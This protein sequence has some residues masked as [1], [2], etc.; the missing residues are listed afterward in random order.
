M[1]AIMDKGATVVLVAES[2]VL[3]GAIGLCDTIKSG[4][5]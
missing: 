5:A 1:H 4:E 2:G 3:L